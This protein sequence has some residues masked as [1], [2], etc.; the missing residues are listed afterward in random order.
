ME[1]APIILWPVA[2]GLQFAAYESRPRDPCLLRKLRSS[3]ISYSWEDRYNVSDPRE[4]EAFH[5]RISSVTRTG[6]FRVVMSKQ[7][8]P[9]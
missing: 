8:R 6:R 4:H 1:A 5:M 9:R 2:A 3:H 7:T